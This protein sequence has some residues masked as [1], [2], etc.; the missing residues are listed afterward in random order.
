MKGTRLFDDDVAC[1]RAEYIPSVV[2]KDECQEDFEWI[3]EQTVEYPNGC[4]MWMGKTSEHGNPI[5]N[6]P[7]RHKYHFLH[8][9]IWEKITGHV[10]YRNN[11]KVQKYCKVHGR[12]CLNPAHYIIGVGAK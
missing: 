12:K 5:T 6:Y 4:W 7:S 3:W 1:G 2:I 10:I 9:V 8:K 11:E